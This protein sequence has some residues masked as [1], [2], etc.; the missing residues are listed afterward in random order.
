VVLHPR[1]TEKEAARVGEL[2]G[3]PVHRS[4]ANF[5]VPVVGACI[6]ANSKGIIVGRPTTPVEI[7]H[8]QEGLSIFD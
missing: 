4:T 3:V 8:I 6:V 7:V 2:L 5:G 1:A